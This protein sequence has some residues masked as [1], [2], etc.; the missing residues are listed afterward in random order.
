MIY[1]KTRAQKSHASVPLSNKMERNK[2]YIVKNQLQLN[3]LRWARDTLQLCLPVRKA[4]VARNYGLR[5][6]VGFVINT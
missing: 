4:S 6:V 2:N 3:I 5:A 1:E